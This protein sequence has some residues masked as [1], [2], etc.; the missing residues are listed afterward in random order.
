[1][2]SPRDNSSDIASE[3]SITAPETLS[4]SS[5]DASQTSLDAQNEQ[6]L[7]SVKKEKIKEACNSG[8]REALVQFA[9]SEG[10]LLEDSLRQSACE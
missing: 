8:D 5:I 10:G 6:A 4:R 7:R 3:Q 9:L 1:M 2:D